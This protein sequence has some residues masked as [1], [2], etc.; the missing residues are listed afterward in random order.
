MDLGEA[1][2]WVNG[3]QKI[4][5]A[6]W[7][8]NRAFS[9]SFV[10]QTR[11]PIVFDGLCYILLSDGSVAFCDESDYEIVT[12]QSM[13][14]IVHGYPYFTDYSDPNQPK[15]VK[16]HQLLN[17][18]WKET[19]HENGNKLDNRRFNLRRCTSQQNNANRSGQSGTTSQ[20]KGVSWDS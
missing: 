15:T 18:E 12:I 7:N 10:P 20:Y 8:A 13:W 19:D 11:D 3:G 16:L 14:S 2:G 9:P 17:P 4:Q 6:G 5:R 1:L